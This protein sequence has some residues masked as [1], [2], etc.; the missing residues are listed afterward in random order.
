[1]CN[2][3]SERDKITS[4]ENIDPQIR[5]ALL[6]PN[7]PGALMTGVAESHLKPLKENALRETHGILIDEIAEL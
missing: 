7:V 4:S 3:Q 1:M 5:A 2:A 6:D